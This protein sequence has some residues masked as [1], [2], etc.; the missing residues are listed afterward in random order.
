MLF[1]RVGNKKKNQTCCGR[2]IELQQEVPSCFSFLLNGQTIRSS[3]SLYHYFPLQP[4][5]SVS[6]LI[7]D[8]L[9]I[10]LTKSK[11]G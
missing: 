2:S 11:A 10:T 3:I 4:A 8:W 1:F 6:K 9:D 5:L 7:L